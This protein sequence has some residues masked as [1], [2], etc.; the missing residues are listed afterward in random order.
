MGVRRGLVRVVWGVP[1]II[2]LASRYS[3]AP[4]KANVRSRKKRREIKAMEDLTLP[5]RRSV[6]IPNQIHKNSPIALSASP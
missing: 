6:V 3:Q 5:K 2:L 4:R 1:G